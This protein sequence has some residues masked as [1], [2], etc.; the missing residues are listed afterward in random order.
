MYPQNVRHLVVKLLPDYEHLAM[1]AELC[2]RLGDAG[3]LK[4]AKISPV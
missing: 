2:K 4:K 3:G 1:V